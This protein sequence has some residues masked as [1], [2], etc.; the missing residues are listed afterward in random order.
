MSLGFFEVLIV[1]VAALLLFGIIGVLAYMIVHIFRLTRKVRDM[2]AQ[3]KQM[4][5]QGLTKGEGNGS[6]SDG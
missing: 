1:M 5:E 3:L 4:A 6:M 2:E